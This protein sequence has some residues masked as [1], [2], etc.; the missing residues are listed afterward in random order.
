MTQKARDRKYSY[1]CHH[2][3]LKTFTLQK[4]TLMEVKSKATDWEKVSANIYPKKDL[5]LV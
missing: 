2:Q 3:N 5:Y 4:N 1:I